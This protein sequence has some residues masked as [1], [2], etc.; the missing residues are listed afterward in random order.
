MS[1]ASSSSTWD[2]PGRARPASSILRSGE[3]QRLEEQ[4]LVTAVR[5]VLAGWQRR[6]DWEKVRCVELLFVRGMPNKEAAA[7]LNISEQAVANY[8]FEFIAKLREGVRSQ[9]PPRDVFPE[10]YE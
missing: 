1:R 4:S 9:G 6:G 2:P 10:L 8:K 5:Q 7:R 3:R